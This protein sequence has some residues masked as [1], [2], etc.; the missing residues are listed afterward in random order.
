MIHYRTVKQTLCQPDLHD[1]IGRVV[2]YGKDV[3]TAMRKS[4]DFNK[5]YVK[6]ASNCGCTYEVEEVP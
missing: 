4:E 1:P 2:Y 5:W 6:Y 3:N